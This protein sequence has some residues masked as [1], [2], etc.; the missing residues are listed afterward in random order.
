MIFCCLNITEIL[1][2]EGSNSFKG[3]GVKHTEKQNQ[4]HFEYGVN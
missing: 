4:T 3:K 2:H 1:F